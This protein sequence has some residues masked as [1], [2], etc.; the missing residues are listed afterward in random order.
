MRIARRAGKHR[1]CEVDEQ[2]GLA[3]LCCRFEQRRIELTIGTKGQCAFVRNPFRKKRLDYLGW[4]LRR[5]W[6]PTKLQRNSPYSLKFGFYP[7]PQR[8]GDSPPG[9]QWSRWSNELLGNKAHSRA[10]AILDLLLK[11]LVPED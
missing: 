1:Q 3:G 10:P 2:V 8:S 7:L 4:N 6:E 9:V 5:L 11:I